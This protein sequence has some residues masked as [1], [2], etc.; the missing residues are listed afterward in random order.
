LNKNNVFAFARAPLPY[1]EE[2][3]CSLYM[4]VGK[5]PLLCG[6]ISLEIGCSLEH[7][8]REM[9]RLILNEQWEQLDPETLRTMKY[10]VRL[11][12]YR[13]KL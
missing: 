8:V 4:R 6:E 1:F 9:E 11:V 5:R 10:D 3:L 2:R 13:C 12:M 7:V